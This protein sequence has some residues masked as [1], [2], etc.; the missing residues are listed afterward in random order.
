[1]TDNGRFD[2]LL[3]VLGERDTRFEK[4]ID[5]L[6]A[7]AT[8]RDAR[9]EQAIDRLDASISV[10]AERQ[11]ASLERQDRLERVMQ[12]GLER[13]DRLE[14]VMQTGFGTLADLVGETNQRLGALEGRFDNLI[15]LVGHETRDLRTDV[16]DL[17]ERVDRIE[18]K[19]G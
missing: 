10:L 5:R 12:A 16:D 13:Q 15:D 11:Q 19:V 7:S 1:M 14:R 2:K 8:E 18:K 4:A 17:K 9:F 3:E 6:E